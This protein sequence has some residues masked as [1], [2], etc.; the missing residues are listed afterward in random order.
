MCNGRGGTL[1]TAAALSTGSDRARE[2]SCHEMQRCIS[3]C[4]A[5]VHGPALR[6]CAGRRRSL[7]LGIG[8]VGERRV[9]DRAQNDGRQPADVAATVHSALIT[10]EACKD[11]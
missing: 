1:S 9:L 3:P 7:E 6:T 10:L 4:T 5:A 8:D 2:R 11:A